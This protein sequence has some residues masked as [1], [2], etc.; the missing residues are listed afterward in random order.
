MSDLAESQ[1]QPTDAY[2][3]LQLVNSSYIGTQSCCSS[4]RSVEA[5]A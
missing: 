3:V 5:K 1:G 2:Q 4:M